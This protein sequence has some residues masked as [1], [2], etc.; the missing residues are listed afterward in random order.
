MPSATTP[1]PKLLTAAAA[2]AAGAALTAKPAC[3]KWC[4]QN[5]SMLIVCPVAPSRGGSATAPT[6]NAQPTHSCNFNTLPASAPA[7]VTPA[8]P[9][10]PYSATTV[11]NVRVPVAAV[12]SQTAGLDANESE[13]QNVRVAFALHP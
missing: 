12:V 10:K 9:S 5:T 7:S 8:P 13:L 6:S 3:S 1:S 2:S 4:K 11:Y